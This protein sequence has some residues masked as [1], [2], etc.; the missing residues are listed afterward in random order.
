LQPLVIPDYLWEIVCIDYVTYLSKSCI[1]GYT[2]VT[3]MAHFVPCHKEI[4]EEESL[5]L[6]ITNCYVVIDNMVFLR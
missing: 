6:F 2:I 5:D 4:I 1:D 3:K